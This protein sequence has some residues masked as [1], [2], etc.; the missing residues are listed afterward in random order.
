MLKKPQ[1]LREGTPELHHFQA[2]QFHYGVVVDSKP[3]VVDD[4]SGPAIHFFLDCEWREVEV[5]P[6]T[7]HLFQW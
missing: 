4:D 7:V 6:Q 3:H 1:D 2:G 5:F